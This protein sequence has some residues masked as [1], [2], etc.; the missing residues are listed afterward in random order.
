MIR[1]SLIFLAIAV[2]AISATV[3][4]SFPA[5]SVPAGTVVSL[6]NRNVVLSAAVT[7]DGSFTFNSVDAGQYEFQ[8]SSSCTYTLKRPVGVRIISASDTLQLGSVAVQQYVVAGSSYSYIWSQDQTYAGTEATANVVP[9]TVITILGN[10]YRLSNLSYAEELK[11]RYNILLVDGGKVWDSEHAYRLFATLDRLPYVDLNPY[12]FNAAAAPSVWRLTSDFLDQDIR[13]EIVDGVKTVTISTAAFVYA[14]PFV[15][16]IEDKRGLYFSKRLHHALVRFVSNNG[17]DTDL[18][19][20]I[21]QKR[22][23]VTTRIPDYAALTGE[24]AGRFQAFRPEELV[25]I[26]NSFEE[27]P[28]G[29]HVIPAL[30]YLIRRLD[31]TINVKYPEAAAIAWSSGYIEFMEK[32]FARNSEIDIQRLILHE[33]GHFI[34]GSVISPA[35]K[36]AWHKLGG[37]YQD[38]AGQ[39]T[40]EKTTEFVSAYAHGKNP[41]ED[42]AETV[43]AFVTNPDILKSRSMAKYEFFRDAIMFGNSYVSQIRQDLTF[44]VLNLFPNYNYPGKIKRVQVSVTGGPDDDKV[45]T[46]EMEIQPVGVKDNPVTNILMR[47]YGPKTAE[48]PVAPYFDWYLNPV[49]PGSSILRGSYTLSKYARKGYWAPDQIVISDSVGNQRYERGVLYGWRCYIDNPLQDLTPPQYVANSARMSVKPGLVEGRQVQILSVD[50]DVVDDRGLMAYTN[51]LRPPGANQY[52]INTWGQPF[53]GNGTAHTEYVITEFFPSGTYRVAQVIMKDYGL[54]FVYAY[55]TAGGGAVDGTGVKIDEPPPSITITTPNP[56]YEPPELDLNRISIVATP[57]VP[58]APNGETQVVI[59]YLA[60]DNKAGVGPVAFRLRDPQGIEHH[61]YHYH[62]NFYGSFFS[63]DP[64][65][66]KQYTATVLLPVGS[67]PG[68][69][70][71][72][73]IDLGDKA[74][75]S[76]SYSFVEIVRFDP[77]STAAADLGITGDPV[78]GSYLAGATA[79]LKVIVVGGNKVSYKWLKNGVALTNSAGS[80]EDEGPR[81]AAAARIMGADSPTLIITGLTADDA[82]S[83]SVVV[84]NAAG[85]VTSKVAALSVASSAVV[86]AFAAQPQARTVRAGDSVTLSATAS[87]TGP[88]SYQW[89]NGGALIAG[90][91]EASLTIS[92]AQ[93]ADAGN[94]SVE[95]RGP[96]GV[97]TSEPVPVV[98][99]TANLRSLRRFT[100]RAVLSETRTTAAGSFAI[101][102]EGFKRVLIRAVGPGIPGASLVGVVPDPQLE[103]RG[104]SGQVFSNNDWSQAANALEMAEA[105]A[106]V[107]AFPLVANSKDAAMLATLPPG[108][109]SVS[110]GGG[111]GEMIFEVYDADISPL[112]TFSSFAFEY[113]LGSSSKW[114]GGLVSAGS[115]GQDVLVRV[116]GPGLG[117]GG[118]PD[119]NVSLFAGSTQV[120]SNNDWSGSPAVAAATTLLGLNPLATASKDSALVGTITANS[121]LSIEVAGASGSTGMARLE[122][123]PVPAREFHSGDFNRDGRLSLTELTRAIELYNTRNGTNRTGAYSVAT[124]STEDGFVTAP[125]R[126]AISSVT[127]NRYHTG[128]TN[129]DGRLSLTELTRMI[130]LYNFRAATTRTGQYRQQTGTED[131]FTP[132]P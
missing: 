28:E 18:I 110:A 16:Q 69:W 11:S 15:A 20:T 105:T 108:F 90:A 19:E 33:K 93:A 21:L 113:P 97:I 119:T 6:S 58:D 26:I 91:T 61:Y 68:T 41:N 39:W 74:L 7:A 44:Q 25:Q 2:R 12:R 88:L 124:S 94:Y 130:E 51:S 107:G 132:G 123:Y 3:S 27:L 81:R 8:L 35:I 46:C 121:A 56:D 99:G 80:T 111:A 14:A 98:V 49:A 89:R 43:A 86:P 75:N 63:G 92:G 83:Y 52:T 59:R 71:L 31:G 95:V 9:P 24:L 17:S 30:K 57:T 115:L 78:G 62:E 125:D 84:S 34:Y 131:G 127:L 122:V 67:V 22:F 23:G 120:A 72:A 109:Y 60:R 85:A 47:V 87:G 106:A 128:D 45:I 70:G 48:L 66:W 102:P 40:T 114:V 10:A 73:S 100:V 77:Y 82:G 50:W 37:W 116:I 32:A 54:N 129:R 36:E 55:F 96:G 53:F 64:S 104:P 76:K 42:F 65:A 117:T 101:G 29:F 118:H 112:A 126:N 79:E 5:G 13:I 103:V 4:G 1:S 38:A